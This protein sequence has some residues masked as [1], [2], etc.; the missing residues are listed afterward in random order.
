[1]SSKKKKPQSDDEEEEDDSNSKIKQAQKKTQEV[2]DL[3]RVNIDLALQRGERLEVLEDKAENL[4]N[5]AQQFQR[6]AKQAKRHFCWQS[7]RN[8]LIIFCLLVVIGLI[9]W[10]IVEAAKKGS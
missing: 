2:A 6:Q 1:M 5:S 9:I 3:A 8:L 10:G 7:W 4:D